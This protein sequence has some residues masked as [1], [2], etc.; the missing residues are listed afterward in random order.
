MAEKLTP[1][2]RREMTRS[3]LID[4]AAELIAERGYEGASLEEIA[5]RAGFTRGAIYSNFEG[6]DDLLL[7]V[8]DRWFRGRFPELEVPDV[9]QGL[10]KRETSVHVAVARAMASFDMRRSRPD[11]V[12][13]SA[14]M[15]L[16]GIRDPEFGVRWCEYVRSR[17]EYVADSLADDRRR[18]GLG[19]SGDP[20]PWLVGHWV[21][22]AASEMA[23]ADPE[24]VDEYRE[25]AEL[26][27]SL[28][29]SFD[30]P[31]SDGD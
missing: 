28:I 20:R 5:K 14:E 23:L 7:A 17:L 3:A 27:F 12:M 13:L 30:A 4:A 2:R 21:M 15:R 25:A 10:T 26:A 11:L 29:T 18:L 1:D 6:K 22:E 9:E 8:L 31:T 16:R 19:A 24:H